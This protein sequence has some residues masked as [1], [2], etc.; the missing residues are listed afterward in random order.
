MNYKAKVAIRTKA[1]I[2]TTTKTSDHT[3]PWLPASLASAAEKEQ[4]L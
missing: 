3:Q 4:L 1:K 2:T